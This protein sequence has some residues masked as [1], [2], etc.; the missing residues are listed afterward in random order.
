MSWNSSCR[1]AQDAENRLVFKASRHRDGEFQPYP[2]GT[3]GKTLNC[4]VKA[5]NRAA[6]PL[7][8][9][10]LAFECFALRHFAEFDG[11]R[12]SDAKGGCVSPLC[13][14]IVKFCCVRLGAL[15]HGIK[16]P[17]QKLSLVRGLNGDVDD[18]SSAT[19]RLLRSLRM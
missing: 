14:L 1:G 2:F 13:L 17:R 6:S 11:A 8:M 3:I 4:C 15:G 9:L 12:P 10:F 7:F 5:I 19:E 16:K 18:Q